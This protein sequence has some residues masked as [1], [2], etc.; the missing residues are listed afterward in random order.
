MIIAYL[1]D[2]R[3]TC[4]PPVIGALPIAAGRSDAGLGKS[5]A[6]MAAETG[7]APVAGGFPSLDCLTS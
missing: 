3:M 1:Y 2:Q 7:A 4:A 6:G 5:D